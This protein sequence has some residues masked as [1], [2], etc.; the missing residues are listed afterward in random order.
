MAIQKGK[1]LLEKSNPTAEESQKSITALQ[2]ESEYVRKS[3][4]AGFRDNYS[5][6]AVKNEIS[7]LVQKIKQKL[8]CI[9]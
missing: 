3:V 6:Q 5:G 8:K 2:T 9:N 1:D 7:D 4:K